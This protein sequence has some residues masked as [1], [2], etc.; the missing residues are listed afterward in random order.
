MCSKNEHINGSIS[1]NFQRKI[2]RSLFSFPSQGE[3]HKKVV[4]NKA[5]VRN[6]TFLFSAVSRTVLKKIP[7][8]PYTVALLVCGF[9]FGLISNYVDVLREYSSMAFMD[10]HTIL[11][12]FL[13][14]LLFESA[15]AME[16][17]TFLKSFSQI[18]LLAVPGLGKY[19]ILPIFFILVFSVS[20][21]ISKNS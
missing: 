20:K 7:Q 16:A 6:I 21:L 19:I 17:H 4:K 15:Y 14:V 12:V 11:F 13:P 5:M 9:I 1:G 18:V 2:S 10:P 8:L 3:K